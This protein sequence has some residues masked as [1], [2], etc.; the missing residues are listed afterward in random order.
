MQ[1]SLHAA[2]KSIALS[3]LNMIAFTTV[4]WVLGIGY[5]VSCVGLS[6]RGADICIFICDCVIQAQDTSDSL[7]RAEEDLPWGAVIRWLLSGPVCCA[8]WRAKREGEM[9]G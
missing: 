3:L 2:R 8:C 5:R 9:E 1:R 4:Y 7:R 6:K